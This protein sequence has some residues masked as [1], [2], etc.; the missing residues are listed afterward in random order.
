MSVSSKRKLITHTFND[1]ICELSLIM[2]NGYTVNDISNVYTMIS[3]SVGVAQNYPHDELD[4]FTNALSFIYKSMTFHLAA[5]TYILGYRNFHISE[6]LSDNE[7][8]QI[9][10]LLM[11]N[12]RN[13][14]LSGH[15]MRI[16]TR[17]YIIPELIRNR[18]L[19]FDKRLNTVIHC[20][21]PFDINFL[22]DRLFIFT[23][24]DP[25]SFGTIKLHRQLK[26][27]IPQLWDK[28]LLSN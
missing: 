23:F 26:D 24:N 12:H 25:S 16:V 2:E 18:V 9:K 14:Y 1:V 13:G 17:C 4:M 20:L 7:I 10:T 3:D 6:F 11:V 8:T 15:T 19:E 5:Q 22:Q 27:M 28:A 21:A